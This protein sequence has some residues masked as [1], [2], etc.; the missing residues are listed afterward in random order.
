MSIDRRTILTTGALAAA[1]C[2][3][4]APIMPAS[5]AAPIAG[6][7]AP[8]VYRYKVG[9]YELTALH[10]GMAARPLDDKFV[11]NA[12]FADVQKALE[13][14]FL[15]K[16]VLNITFTTILVNTGSK[17]V[18]ID[19]GFADNGPPTTGGV[20]AG[21][22]ASGIDPKAIDTVI[23]SHFHPDHIQGVRLKSGA[24]T[25]PNAEIMVPAAEWAFWMDDSRMNNAPDGLKPTFQV[26][27]RVFSPIAK[28]VKQYEWGKEVVP[29][30]TAIE[31]PGH[32]PGH[33]AFVIASGNGK[34]LLWSDTTNHPALFVRNPEWQ[35]I[36]DMDGN[37]ATTT[38][39]KLLDMAAA[40]KMQVA[41][42]HLPFPATGYITKTG[43]KYDLVPVAWQSIL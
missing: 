24:A 35:A 15:P 29:G 13:T 1:S 23:I 7:Q 36:F 6:K 42:Y 40:D 25:Y 18:L 8:G 26:S 28:D 27:R 5:A 39:K 12:P 22:T 31:A 17:L 11:R 9:D 37:Q 41:G 19:T 3:L 32:T 10:E 21:L 14:A 38:R 33:T 30:I 34:L 16:N 43:D 2:A 20:A 4:P